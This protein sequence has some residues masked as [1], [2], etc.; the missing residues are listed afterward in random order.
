MRL[1]ALILTANALS[2]LPLLAQEAFELDTIVVT[3]NLE[4]TEASRTGAS[5]SVVTEEDL[6]KTAETKL[7]D[8]LARLPGVS[9]RTTGPLGSLGGISVRGASQNYVTVTVDGIDITDPSQPQV[10]A[11]FGALTTMDVSR[12]EV[13]RGSQSALYG[14]RA[15]GGVIAITTRRATEEGVR[16][17]AAAE[18]GSYGTAKLSY[19]YAMK[20]GATDV[21]LTLSH[22]Q[23]D[24]FSAADEAD[25]NTEA[26]G[27]RAERLSLAFGH[28]FGGGTKLTVTGF[29]EDADG[30]FDEG[31]PLADGTPDE[32]VES[33]S[34]GLRGAL[35]FTT[36]A[37]DNTLALTLYRTERD[38]ESGTAFGFSRYGYTGT[39]TALSYQGATDLSEAARLVFGG[40]ITRE[41][42][43]QRGDFGAAD[44]YT[45]L[46]GVFGEITWAPTDQ[47]DIAATLRHDDNSR[48]GGFTTGRVSVAYRPTPDLTL[49]AVAATGFRAPSNYELF[50]D[51][52][53]NPAL[54][55]EES[56]SFELGA[57]YALANGGSLSATAFLLE[58]EN[59]IDYSFVTSAYVQV[60][61]T[62]R[63][64]GLE[65]AADVPLSDRLRVTAA[66]TYTDSR[67]NT[68]SSWTGVPEHMASLGLEADLADRL[69]GTFTV[70]RAVGRDTLPPYTVANATVTYD[71]GQGTE[72][73]LRIENIFDEQY[74]LVEGYGTSD[75]ALYLGLRK[76]F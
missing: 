31:F 4:E 23:T 54:E 62:S 36:G 20:R 24:G 75:R 45:T 9:V 5:V 50:G 17:E 63:R 13:L 61:G 57:E 12:I 21:A 11:N 3:A 47:L 32:T 46:A 42:Y 8:Y 38:Y 10:S 15:V 39:R 1:T 64:K 65:L 71:I 66:Y 72:G 68:A 19:G 2:P 69:R 22:V 6:K 16:Q 58:A 25:G 26:D 14:S 67:A 40:D 43:K 49:R 59:L 74:Q 18:A 51:F 37:L 60:P 7:T 52:V 30:D 55:P 56:A 33:R 29:V 35:D 53:G 70:E 27:Y 76:S 28:D 41:G 48:F 34:A 73:Y 44:A